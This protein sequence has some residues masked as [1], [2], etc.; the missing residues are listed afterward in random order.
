MNKPPITTPYTRLEIIDDILYGVFFTGITIDL[1]IAKEI[2]K[3]RLEYT[4][5]IPYPMFIHDSGVVSMNKEA[6]D[7]FSEKDGGMQGTVAAALLLK[8][9]YSEFLGNFFL[10]I[11][12]PDMPTK[13][14]TD[15]KKALEWL[16]QF[17]T[18]S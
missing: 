12:K 3:T 15:E 4:D 2:V 8:S 9:V 1:D 7:Y 16:Q 14:F 17:K 5:Y 6:R 10:R 13:I 18:K 11:T